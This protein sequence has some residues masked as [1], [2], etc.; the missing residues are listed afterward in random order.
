LVD[1]RD[2][3]LEELHEQADVGAAQDDL[4]AAGLAIDVLQVRDDPVAGP[5]ALARRLLARRQDGLGAA[6]VDDDVGA[7]LE[8]ADDAGDQLA[9]AVLELV[10]DELALGVADTLDDH[11]LRRLRGDATEPATVLLEAEQ[12]AVLTVLLLRLLGVLGQV[13]DLEAEILT[14][15]SVVEAVAPGVLDRDLALRIVDLLHDRH[16]LIEVDVARFVAE[17]GL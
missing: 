14:D 3:H 6:E 4:R 8:P 13:E 1:L 9:L 15:L 2:L 12:I 16:E 17:A 11:L 5:V 10:E 7:A